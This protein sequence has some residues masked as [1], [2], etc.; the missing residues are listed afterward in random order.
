MFIDVAWLVAKHFI[1][2]VSTLTCDWTEFPILI[3]FF[4]TRP[5]FLEKSPIILTGSDP[6]IVQEN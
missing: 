6:V 3:S 5:C 2:S 4:Q 1:N